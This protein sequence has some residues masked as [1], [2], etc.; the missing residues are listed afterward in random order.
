[1]AT[2]LA[3]AL[4][5]CLL[6]LVVVLALGASNL[7]RGGSGARSQRLQR[8]RVGLQGVAIVLFLALVAVRG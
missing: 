3:V 1:M 5:A 7:A 8:I 6:G 2:V 4:G